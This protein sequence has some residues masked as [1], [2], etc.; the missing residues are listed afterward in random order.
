MT[1]KEAEQKVLELIAKAAEAETEVR[2]ETLLYEDLGLASVE[3]YVM[4]CELE[5]TFGINLSA[6]ALRD[7]CT[8]GDLCNLV[9]K[10]LQGK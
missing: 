4:L 3:V 10:E 8:V 2:E 9:M 5:E 6:A 7:V 1:K